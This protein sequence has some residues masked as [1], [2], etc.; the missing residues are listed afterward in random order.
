[1]YSTPKLRK[2]LFKMEFSL[3]ASRSLNFIPSLKIMVGFAGETD[4]LFSL[5]TVLFSF[6]V[7]RRGFKIYEPLHLVLETKSRI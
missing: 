2:H 6:W 5:R 1:M 4:A 7:V 3:A